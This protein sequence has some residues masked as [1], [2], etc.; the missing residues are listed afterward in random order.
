MAVPVPWSS[1]TA[2]EKRTRTLEV[3]DELFAREG[4]D[5]PMPTLAHALGVGV[6]SIYRQVG[7]KDDVLAALV[8]TRSK[9]LRERFLA[10]LDQPDPWAALAAATHATVD[11]CLGDA[12]SQSAWDVAASASTEVRAARAGATDALAQMVRRARDAG[13]LRDDASHEDLRLV[14]CA[15]RELAGI[16]PEAAHR[17]AELA[18]RGIRAAPLRSKGDQSPGNG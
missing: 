4:V 2:D 11:D 5:V 7:T 6:G 8:I 12:L 18:L 13:A 16:G 14:F 3:A 17:L 10:T 15:L 1:L 9:A